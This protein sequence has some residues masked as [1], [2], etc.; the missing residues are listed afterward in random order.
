MISAKFKERREKRERKK[1]ASPTTKCITTNHTRCPNRKKILLKFQRHDKMIFSVTAK[2]RTRRTK[3]TDTSHV[4]T[5]FYFFNYILYL[6][7][8]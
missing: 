1:K 5:I 4:P 7:R 3:S 8:Y 6:L 2:L